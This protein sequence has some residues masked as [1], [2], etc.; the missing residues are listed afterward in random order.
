M[1]EDFI[2]LIYVFIDQ[3]ISKNLTKSLIKDKFIQFRVVL[4][5]E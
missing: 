3:I 1:I 2:Y 5:I 4:K